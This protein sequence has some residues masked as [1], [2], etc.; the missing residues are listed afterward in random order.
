MVLFSPKL[1]NRP[2]PNTENISVNPTEVVEK[3]QK[4][5][6]QSDSESDVEKDSESDE[7]QKDAKLDTEKKNVD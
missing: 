2:N 1:M 7:K 6:E 3:I 4:D 5:V